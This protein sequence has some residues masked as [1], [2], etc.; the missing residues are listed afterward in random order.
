MADHAN[1]TRRSFLKSAPLTAVAASMIPAV[2]TANPESAKDKVNRLAG[3]LAQ[4][5]D[6]FDNGRWYA[7]VFQ[8]SKSYG[9]F[10]LFV[11]DIKLPPAFEVEAAKERL[12]AAMA[13]MYPDRDIVASSLINEDGDSV[14]HLQARA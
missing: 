8:A 4:A 10:Q 11:S 14:F 2:V 6:E 7:K 3:E 1:T 13:K 12:K 5:L 9:G